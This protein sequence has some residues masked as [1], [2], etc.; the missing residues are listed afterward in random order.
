[1]V[2]QFRRYHPDKL[3]HTEGQTN[4]WTDK[5]NIPPPP[6][7][8][9]AVS[10]FFFLSAGRELMAFPENPSKRGKSHHHYHVQ[11]E[12]LKSRREKPPPPPCRKGMSESK[13]SS[14]L[15]TAATITNSAMLLLLS[16]FCAF[17]CHG[18]LGLLLLKRRHKIINVR[19]DF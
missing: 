3:G 14:I 4:G 19:N 10:F 13:A 11:M 17:P 8:Y 1:M 9:R 16:A 5:V 6:Y 7:L 15:L 2:K 18:P 12:G